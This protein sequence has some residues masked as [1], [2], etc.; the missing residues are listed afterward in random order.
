MMLLTT[1]SRLAIIFVIRHD[2]SRNVLDRRVR[3]DRLN[4]LKHDPTKA[5]T[6]Y[7]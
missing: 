1:S 6:V 3:L 2:R 7:Q 5:K 4:L